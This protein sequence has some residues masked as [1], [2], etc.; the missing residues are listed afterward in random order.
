MIEKI[1]NNLKNNACKKIP[2]I[3]NGIN[4]FSLQCSRYDGLIIKSETLIIRGKY[5]ISLTLKIV[6]TIVE[7][8]K[9]TKLKIHFGS[10]V[11][12]V[13]NN[14]KKYSLFLSIN[15]NVNLKYLNYT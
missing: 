4:L 12:T 6:L 15:N 9:Q 3:G 5:C 8:S 7:L 13:N 11:E 2:Y 1:P 14:K 10:I